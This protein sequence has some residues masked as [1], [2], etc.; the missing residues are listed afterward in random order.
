[1]VTIIFIAAA[2]G[3]CVLLLV[4]E[5]NSEIERQNARHELHRAIAVVSMTATLLMAS[6]AGLP[7]SATRTQ[8]SLVEW[9]GDD[10]ACKARI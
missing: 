4:T 10:W 8:A 2:V 7:H 9:T 5:S 6:S 1:V 3:N